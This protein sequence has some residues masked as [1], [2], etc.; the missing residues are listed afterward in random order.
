MTG[1][2]HLFVK[3]DMKLC[4]VKFCGYSSGSM[5]TECAMVCQAPTPPQPQLT[6]NARPP[7]LDTPPVQ[8]RWWRGASLSGEVTCIKVLGSA[9]PRPCPDKHSVEH[10]RQSS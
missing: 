1:G 7:Q 4:R 8:L 6:G 2:W 9:G 10:L 5:L 3:I